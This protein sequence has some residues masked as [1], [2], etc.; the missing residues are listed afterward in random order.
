MEYFGARSGEPLEECLEA[1]RRA[2]IYVGVIGTRYGSKDED[3]IS[4]TQREYEE[5]YRQ[6]KTILIYLLDE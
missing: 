5:A 4:I 1:V 2:Q 6:K 3:G